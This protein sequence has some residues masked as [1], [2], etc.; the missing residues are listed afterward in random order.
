MSRLDDKKP[1]PVAD[2]LREKHDTVHKEKSKLKESK[3]MTKKIGGENIMK[4]NEKA[5]VVTTS[6]RGVFFGY[7]NKGEPDSEKQILLRRCRNC[8]YWSAQMRGFGGL[9]AYGP[10]KN[11]KIGPQIPEILLH[12]ITSVSLITDSKVVGKWESNV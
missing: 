5:V 9:I 8:L 11:C 4:K 7:I 10:D 3:S 12:D 2:L 6:H 1:L